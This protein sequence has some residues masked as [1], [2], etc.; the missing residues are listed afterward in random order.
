MT[1]DQ[2][3]GTY[4][5]VSM[6]DSRLRTS[7]SCND[8]LARRSRLLTG[9]HPRSSLSLLPAC[10]RCFNC[11]TRL[12]P[13][14]TIYFTFR[15]RGGGGKGGESCQHW[16]P[17]DKLSSNRRYAVSDKPHQKLKSCA[18][19]SCMTMSMPLHTNQLKKTDLTCTV[20][21]NSCQC[22][23]WAKSPRH[24]TADT[25]VAPPN[26]ATMP[27]NALLPSP[28][29]DGPSNVHAQEEGNA[30]FVG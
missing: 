27:T 18:S 21:K 25:L 17:P 30:E 5:K 3:S 28:A 19:R 7:S 26:A 16:P 9:E 20:W 10:K 1:G 13:P 29:E 2:E 24:L 6:A 4:C 22:S 23:W 8:R 14:P 15:G 12:P 11:F